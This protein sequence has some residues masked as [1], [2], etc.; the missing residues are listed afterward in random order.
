MQ[1]WPPRC[2]GTVGHGDRLPLRAGP[3]PRGLIGLDPALTTRHGL[4]NRV[5]AGRLGRV[6]GQLENRLDGL[7]YQVGEFIGRHP[8]LVAA[9]MVMPAAWAVGAGHNPILLR[10]SAS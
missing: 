9:H 3:G 8:Q 6:A 7:R 5:T 1:A 4:T 10:L 2:R